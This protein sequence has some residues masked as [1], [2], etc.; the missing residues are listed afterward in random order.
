MGHRVYMRYQI[1]LQSRQEL[2]GEDWNDTEGLFG[3]KYGHNTHK[4]VV[5]VVLKWPHIC[6]SR[7]HV[8]SMLIIF[9]DCEGVVHYEFSPRGQTINKECYVE[10]LKRLRDAVRR[11]RP[12]F[13]SSGDWLLRHDNALA[14][15]SNLVQQFLAKHK[16]V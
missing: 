2:Y 6:Q 9:I 16:I 15:S 7:S 11:K 10:V 13:W 5:Q 1:L 4:G 12:R 3:Q 8:K 14:H